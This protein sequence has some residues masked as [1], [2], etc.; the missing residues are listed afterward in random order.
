[1]ARFTP[2]DRVVRHPYPDSLT[3]VVRRVHGDGLVTVTAYLP[4][5][6]VEHSLIHPRYIR[7]A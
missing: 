7:K 6:Q 3:Y 5:G 4:Y 1:M 2:G